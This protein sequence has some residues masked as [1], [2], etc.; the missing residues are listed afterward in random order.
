MA[1][2]IDAATT[3]DDM[4]SE[5]LYTR[6]A[7]EADPDARDLLPSTDGWMALVDEARARGRDAREAVAR[8]DAQ[9]R[10]ANGR[11][12]A[13]CTS[14]GDALI[15]AVGKDRASARWR[16][17]LTG[18]I[19]TM[20]AF[21]RQPLAQQVTSVKLWLGITD[22]PS[23]E[24]HRAALTEW[25]TAT[26]GALT[27]TGAT[28]TLRGTAAVVRE[29]VAEDLTRARD[30]L[31]AALTQRAT[32]RRLPRGWASLFFRTTAAPTRRAPGAEEP[33][34]EVDPAPV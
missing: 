25:S 32:E 2:R 4:E 28:A 7:V 5:I 11:L 1:A 18:G 26:D 13:A 27:S 24:P 16:R 19:S 10:V 22:E 9:R 30:G 8:A 23:L 6:A 20:S 31:D 12:D 15:L 14:F 33:N 29:R 3:F 17:F 21:I 34:P